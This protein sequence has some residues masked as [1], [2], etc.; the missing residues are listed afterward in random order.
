MVLVN[1]CIFL[2]IPLA[3]LAL[4]WF[5][6]GPPDPTDNDDRGLPPPWD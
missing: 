2:G 6:I 5:F 1:L 3:L 4:R